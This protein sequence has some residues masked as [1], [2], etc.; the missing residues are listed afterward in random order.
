MRNKD[1]NCSPHFHKLENIVLPNMIYW[2][3]VVLVIGSTLKMT[4]SSSRTT[5]FQKVWHVTSLPLSIIQTT[6]T[7][8]KWAT[9]HSLFQG[10]DWLYLCESHGLCRCQISHQCGCLQI[11]QLQQNPRSRY[12]V[13]QSLHSIWPSPFII[14]IQQCSIRVIAISQKLHEINHW[15]HTQRHSIKHSLCLMK[16]AM[17]AAATCIARAEHQNT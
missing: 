10:F 7:K 5:L 16:V 4:C 1:I 9:K 13:L 8:K 12:L 17:A 3:Y 14:P 15:S 11:G 6:N 2:F